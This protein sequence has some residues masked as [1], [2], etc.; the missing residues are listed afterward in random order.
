LNITPK[1]YYQRLKELID[2]G[3]VEKT[4]IGYQHTPLG[5]AVNNINTSLIDVYKNKEKIEFLGKFMNTTALSEEEKASIS[6]ILVE[7]TQIGQLM[8]HIVEA[9]QKKIEKIPSYENLVKRVCE[10]LEKTTTSLYLAT[11]YF[12]PDV[13]ST[14]F[15][16]YQKG[17]KIQAIMPGSSL[18][19][20]FNKL[21]MIMSPKAL[22]T[23]IDVLRSSKNPSELYRE[24][25]VLFSLVIIDNNRCFFEFPK[26]FEEEFTVAFYVEDALLATKFAKVFDKIWSTANKDSFEILKYFKYI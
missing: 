5:K 14:C 9:G 19:N 17:V 1:R 15:K 7:G 10:E 11:S 6:N 2:L 21:R 3:L 23:I 20:K 26:I 4:E 24:N 12:D 22:M 18:T 16:V 8:N 25:E 13:I